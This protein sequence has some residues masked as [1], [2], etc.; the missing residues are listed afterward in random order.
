MSGVAMAAP[1]ANTNFSPIATEIQEAKVKIEP[2]A[3]P[4]PVKTAIANDASVSSLTISEAWQWAT[5]EGTYQF[6]V[7]FD[8]GTEDKLSKKYDQEGNEI[9]G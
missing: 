1:V 9:K 5:P 2:D 6:K 3:L 8:N 7:V 4:E